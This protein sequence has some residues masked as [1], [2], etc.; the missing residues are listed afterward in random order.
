MKIQ[1]SQKDYRISK[2]VYNDIFSI[3]SSILK[4]FRTRILRTRLL[5]ICLLTY[6]F[7]ITTSQISY[8]KDQYM[9]D[10][11][12]ARVYNTSRKLFIC[13]INF[14]RHQNKHENKWIHFYGRCI[15]YIMTYLFPIVFISLRSNTIYIFHNPGLLIVYWLTCFANINMKGTLCSK[16]KY[17]CLECT[18]TCLD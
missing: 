10:M 6:N 17:H 1:W 7:H 15:S 13:R 5:Q 9:F 8:I 2:F 18:L 16:T 12:D 14:M 3:Y 11:L 4:L